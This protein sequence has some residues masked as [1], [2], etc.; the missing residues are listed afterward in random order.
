MDYK[1]QAIYENMHVMD[2]IDTLN[3]QGDVN[4]MGTMSAPAPEEAC[5]S[6]EQDRHFE[7]E[8]DMAQS[9]VQAIKK[10]A[11]CIADDLQSLPR[12][13]GWVQAKLTICSEYLSDVADFVDYH[14]DKQECTTTKTVMLSIPMSGPVDAGVY[15]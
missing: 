1:L 8:A 11:E 9:A 12:I 14:A 6:E 15:M 5:E 2:R 4:T 10:H 13:P 3:D 7:Q